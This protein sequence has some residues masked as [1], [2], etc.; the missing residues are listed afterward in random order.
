MLI[1][2]LTILD[3]Y[4]LIDIDFFNHFRQLPGKAICLYWIAIFQNKLP[5]SMQ[6]LEFILTGEIRD[7]GLQSCVGFS[8]EQLPEAAGFQ[9][10]N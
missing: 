1:N 2:F 9:I 7:P 3:L 8:S 4:S 5:S 10:C 6:D